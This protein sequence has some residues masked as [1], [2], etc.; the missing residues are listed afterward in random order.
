ME[1]ERERKRE[2]GQRGERMRD[3]GGREREKERKG[4][5]DKERGERMRDNGGRETERE[6]GQRG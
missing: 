3:N 2:E 6:E 1:E 4:K 5:E